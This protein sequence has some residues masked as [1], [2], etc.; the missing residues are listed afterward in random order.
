MAVS[1]PLET[2][3][4]NDTA[5]N[6][7]ESNGETENKYKPCMVNKNDKIEV[8]EMIE[9]IDVTDDASVVSSGT[10]TSALI[11]ATENSTNPNPN[12]DRIKARLE[13][14]RK[15][16]AN[17]QK[18]V[19][20]QVYS[21]SDKEENLNTSRR[22]EEDNDTSTVITAATAALTEASSCFDESFVLNNGEA[23]NT[24]AISSILDV[25][26]TNNVNPDNSNIFSMA[27]DFL[28]SNKA[29]EENENGLESAME[30]K[31]ES[32]TVSLDENHHVTASEQDNDNENQTVATNS[33]SHSS[34]S[35]KTPGSEKSEGVEIVA[36]MEKFMCAADSWVANALGTSNAA[37]NTLSTNESK[38]KI[39]ANSR[40]NGNNMSSKSTIDLDQKISPM[41]RMRTKGGGTVL[42]ETNTNS[43]TNVLQT[44]QTWDNQ[45]QNIVN[46]LND[47]QR[48][49][50]LLGTCE[51]HE[52][53]DTA[54]TEVTRNTSS[55]RVSKSTP[56][57][58]SNLG[59][60]TKML[61]E[62][63]DALIASCQEQSDDF[64][65]QL[66]IAEMIKNMFSADGSCATALA[67]KQ[68]Y[69]DEDN[70]ENES[71]SDDES[72]C[73]YDDESTHASTIS[74]GSD[75]SNSNR[76]SR[77]KS[78]KYSDSDN[79]EN[80]I[81]LEKKRHLMTQPPPPPPPKPAAMS[82]SS[83]STKQRQRAAK[84]K[85]EVKNSRL[86][87]YAGENTKSLTKGVHR[88]D[89][90]KQKNWRANG[91]LE[92]DE[93]DEIF[94]EQF[95]EVGS[96]FVLFHKICVKLVP[97]MWHKPHQSFYFR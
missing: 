59:A 11:R 56:T 94:V 69:S 54:A 53:T 92:S 79:E 86:S 1:D 18:D 37:N 17:K 21:V 31:N 75:E 55:S 7:S 5:S 58:L 96:F 68:I 52:S 39:D 32:R 81:L 87:K 34:K 42:N 62:N 61:E 91:R 49:H 30:A 72:S 22:N 67:N 25:S 24:S 38:W 33:T 47:N 73:F 16:A 48:Q 14:R 12:A 57:K 41:A 10:S 93:D 74:E 80:D 8:L 35:V 3:N 29:E 63:R 60:S 90:V 64:L 76:S 45:I 70:E 19:R 6:K 85:N 40:A 9:T 78:T 97:N 51:S 44:T 27:V 66:G 88:T 2:S 43:T 13:R 95:I 4:D 26:D 15:R 82:S 36:E 50:H 28:L 83:S 84:S 23:M 77:S 20:I 71:Y 65:K 46:R 89:S